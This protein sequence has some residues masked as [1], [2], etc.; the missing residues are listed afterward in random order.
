M[1][2]RIFFTATG[3]ALA[4]LLFSGVFITGILYAH[5]DAQLQQQMADKASYLA[6]SLEKQGL[7]YLDEILD[8][9]DD[10]TRITLIAA[11][12]TVTFD[13]WAPAADMENHL[14]REEVQQALADGHGVSK[15]HSATVAELTSYYALRLDDSSV[16]RL[17]ESHASLLSLLIAMLQPMAFIMLPVMLLAAWLAS[18]LADQI[19][20]P[21]ADIDLE[22]PTQ[23]AIYDELTPFIK[24]I[25]QQQRQIKSHMD[26][27][28]RQQREFQS[29]TDNMTEGFA[30]IDNRTIILSHNRSIMRLFGLEGTAEGQSVLVLNR[31]E[32]F[33]NAIQQALD[34]SHAETLLEVSGR[35]FRLFCSPARQSG[36]IAGAILLVM[37]TT[38]KVERENLRREFTANVSHELKTPLTA[39]SGTAEII[40]SGIAKPQDVPHFAETIYNETQRLITLV[41]DIILLSRLDENAGIPDR[42]PVDLHSLTA[43]VLAT[44]APAADRDNITLELQGESTVISGVPVLLDEL[45]FNLCDNAVKYNRPGGSVTVRLTQQDDRAILSVTDTG[46]GIPPEEHERIFERFYRV[47]KSHSREIGGTGLGLSIVKH[48]AALHGAAI[49]LQSKPGQGTTITVSFPRT[50]A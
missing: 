29:I 39:I 15:R 47:D 43:R 46:M 16:L 11:D 12:G 1:K 4:V 9:V 8:E 5:L 3:L 32:D 6:F 25:S 48:S 33:R 7:S 21:L 17:A 50:A 13:N 27:L 40:K 28:Q 34:G 35:Y 44:L 36:R 49:S 18:R 26:E 14:D 2:Q 30:V 41:N 19:V 38:E 23:I 42:Q 22:H 10:A 45:V 31:G 24:R 20:R 37:D